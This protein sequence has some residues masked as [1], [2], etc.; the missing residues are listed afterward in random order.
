MFFKWRKEKKR[1]QCSVIIIAVI[2]CSFF[3]FRGPKFVCVCACA[4]YMKV[5]RE[6]MYVLVCPGWK[7]FK[8]VSLYSFLFFLPYYFKSRSTSCVC[9]CVCVLVVIV[10]KIFPIGVKY[11]SRVIGFLFSPETVFPRKKEKLEK[12]NENF[13]FNF[14]TMWI[15][16]FAFIMN[17]KR[18]I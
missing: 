3:L 11:F 16:A 17:T 7:F 15:S 5:C 14:L 18:S 10:W 4:Y 9:L 13:F 12:E 1:K 2:F 6:I 8:S